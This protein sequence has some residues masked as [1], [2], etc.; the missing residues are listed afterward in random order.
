MS[1][2]GFGICVAMMAPPRG[3]GKM[4]ALEAC[5]GEEAF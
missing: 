2:P 3:S 1:G 4:L 5:R